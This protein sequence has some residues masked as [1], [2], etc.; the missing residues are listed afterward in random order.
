MT[1]IAQLRK[2][3]STQQKQIDEQRSV[4][5]KQQKL[6]EE[7]TDSIINL[8]KAIINIEGKLMITESKYALASHVNSILSKNVDELQQYSRRSCIIIDGIPSSQA[9]DLPQILCENLNIPPPLMSSEV[10]KY[11]P[12]GPI[13]EDGTQS[14]IL[15]VRSHGFRE[16]MYRARKNMA[17]KKYKLRV[18]LTD[19]RIKLIESAKSTFKS[20]KV[21]NIEFVFADINGNVK[22]KFISRVNRSLFADI[23]NE[24]SVA[25]IIASIGRPEGNFSFDEYDDDDK[26]EKKADELTEATPKKR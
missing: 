21:D 18:S 11:H 25:A 5:D 26:T 6:I 24:N 20:Q 22:V 17:N 23:E 10:D 14:V 7:N 13:K 8:K 4:I 15:K 3:I 12:I 1:E 2:L 9:N 19:R 16:K